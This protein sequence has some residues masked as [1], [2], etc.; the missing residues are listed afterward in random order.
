MPQSEPTRANAV[1]AIIARCQAIRTLIDQEDDEAKVAELCDAEDRLLLE[2][3]TRSEPND[4]AF[5]AKVDYLLAAQTAE[6]GE[7]ASQDLFGPVVIALRRH[8]EQR[9]GA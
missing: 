9:H 6:V 3:A 2:L 5:F 4:D 7:P 1:E 8:L